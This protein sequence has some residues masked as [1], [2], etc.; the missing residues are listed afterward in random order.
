MGCKHLRRYD[1]RHTGLTWLAD[2][3]VLNHTLQ[4]IAG[5]GLITTTRR[6]LYP[7]RRAI[8]EAKTALSA[9]LTARRSPSGPH[10]RAV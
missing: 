6:Y 3:G 5:H 10:L 9:H 4:K 1:L 2:A 7:D 8:D